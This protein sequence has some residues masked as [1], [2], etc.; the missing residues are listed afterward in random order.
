MLY[1][2]NIIL[3]TNDIIFISK[4]ILENKNTNKNM[5]KNIT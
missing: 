2:K 4:I 3:I 1:M 5:N